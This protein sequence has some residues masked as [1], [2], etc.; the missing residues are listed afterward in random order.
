MIICC[1]R[2]VSALSTFGI[3]TKSCNVSAISVDVAPPV[4]S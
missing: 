2:L 3:V 4:G 1:D